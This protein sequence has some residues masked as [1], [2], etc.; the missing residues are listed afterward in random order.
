MRYLVGENVFTFNSGIEF[1]QF[2]RLKVFNDSN[3]DTVI[4]L[5][6]YNRMLNDELKKHGLKQKD[7][8][9]MYDFFREQFGQNANGNHCV[10]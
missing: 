10:C 4:L 6:N 7:V 2:E 3:E 5:R 8:I 9:N 1:S